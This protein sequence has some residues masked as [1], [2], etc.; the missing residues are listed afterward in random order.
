M[1]MGDYKIIKINS[2]DI[3]KNIITVKQFFSSY[4]KEDIYIE[5][6]DDEV[7]IN[8][9]QLDLPNFKKNIQ[10]LIKNSNSGLSEL[11]NTILTNIEKIKS[12]G[13]KGKKRLYIGYNKERKV[14]DRKEKEEKRGPYYYAKDNTFSKRNNE[15]PELYINKIITGDSEEILKSLPENCIDLIFTS[16]PYNFGL[17]Y[18]NHKDGINWDGYFEK[19]FKVFKECIRVLKYSGRIIVNVQPLFSDYVPIHHILSDFFMKQKMIWRGE[20]IW[21]KHN[22]NCKYTAWGSWQSPSS[23]YLKYTW[24]FLEIFCKGDLKKQGRSED[25]DISA[26]EFKKYVIGKWDIAPERNMKEY[27]HPAMFPEELAERVL[28]L[29]SYKEDMV[30]DPFNGV[31]TTTAVAKKLSRKYFGIDISDEYCRK[32]EDRLKKTQINTAL[33]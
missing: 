32:A 3:K 16:P 8:L 19:L 23:P 20:I 9:K 26:E 10:A 17:D 12:Y 11:L 6:N 24:E 27:K 1:I 18:D 31:G 22:W 2:G 29:F 28:K 13:L 14:R 7:V 4:P 30:L 5:F 33:F 25:I 15:V 21:D